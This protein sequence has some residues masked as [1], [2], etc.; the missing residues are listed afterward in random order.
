MPL[1]LIRLLDEV[2]ERMEQEPRLRHFTLDG[3]SSLIDAYLKVRPE[4]FERV[5]KLVKEG[6]LLLGP[7]Y[8]AP[9]PA[10]TNVESLIRNLLLGLRTAR[11]F[12]TPMMVAYLPESG[13]LHSALPQ[14]LKSF[15][16]KTVL[17]SFEDT[18]EGVEFHYR[19]LDGTLAVIG[20]LRESLFAS[21]DT[22]VSIRR[23]LAPLSDSGHLLLLSQWEVGTTLKKAGTWLRKLAKAASDLQDDVI[24]STPA[25]FAN[26]L[27]VNVLNSEL[28]IYDR[29]PELTAAGRQVRDWNV[30]ITRGVLRWIEPFFAWA[31]NAQLGRT[32]SHL[33]RPQTLIQD[34]WRHILRDQ[35]DPQ[36]HEPENVEQLAAR[37]RYYRERV[38]DLRDVPLN[39]MTENV[40]TAVLPVQG[41]TALIVYNSNSQTY[42]GAFR[43][44]IG[45]ARSQPEV[46]KQYSLVVYN[47]NGQRVGMAVPSDQS[48]FVQELLFS[49]E[50]PAFGYSSFSVALE[51]TPTD[52]VLP[53]TKAGAAPDLLGYV[54]GFHP[55]SL[56]LSTGLISVSDWRFEVTTIKLPENPDQR[57]LILR[58]S[59]RVDEPLMVT[60][61]PWRVFKKCEVVSM[62]EAPIGGTVAIDPATGTLKFKATAHRLIT[63]WLHD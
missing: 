46:D 63:L 52:L 47:A 17:A 4:N 27:E 5:E 34:L 23:K 6:R 26:A 30:S 15:G 9:E 7:W 31:E 20:D 19:G 43:F 39:S 49:A 57:G 45:W 16:I 1:F 44:K 53:T 40:N 51:P 48:E 25:A 55:G 8:V 50:I 32:E 29:Q 38:D 59:C 28:P 37:T 54:T 12:G 14:I 10:L 3:E 58:G 41:V 61:T 33:R 36:L 2:L 18:Q 56:P 11:V 24:V 60:L 13:V 35:A 22:F 21:D 62:D 42:R